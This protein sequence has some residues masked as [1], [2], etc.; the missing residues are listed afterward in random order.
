MKIAVYGGSFDPFHIGH[1]SIVSAVLSQLEI[2]KIMIVPTFLNPFKTTSYLDPHI[3][4]DIIQELYKDHRKVKILDF[5]LKQNKPTPTIDTINYILDQYSPSKI[6]LIIGADNLKSLHLWQNFEQLNQLVTFVVISRKGYEE[7][8]GIIKFI[9]IKLDVNIS[10]T[11]LRKNLDLKYI[12]KKI[13]QKVKQIW[14]KNK[15]F[16]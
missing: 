15:E 5:E 11:T 16:N 13:E 8:N 12:P 4:F 1:E 6:Y 9:N 3:R 14:N 10:S 7:K 2:D